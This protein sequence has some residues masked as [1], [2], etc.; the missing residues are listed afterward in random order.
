[1]NLPHGKVPE[2]D[3]ITGLV[4]HPSTKKLPLTVNVS[5]E[6]VGSRRLEENSAEQ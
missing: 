4:C 3:F 2:R 1:M 5:A 6:Y